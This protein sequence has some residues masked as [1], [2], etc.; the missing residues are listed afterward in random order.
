MLPFLAILGDLLAAEGAAGA[1][2]SAVGPAIAEGAASSAIP[3]VASAA[4][5]AASAA[6]FM[7]G[8]S[9]FMTKAG[10]LGSRMLGDNFVGRTAD[11]AIQSQLQ[12]F[13]GLL[14]KENYQSPEGLMKAFGPFMSPGDRYGAGLMTK[15][16]N[17]KD[18]DSKEKAIKDLLKAQQQ[19]GNL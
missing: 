3:A 10:S 6:S 14:T 4:A 7:P 19:S 11:T 8:V 16:F 15:A 5:P 12:P 17:W 2:G 18:Q 9:G 1:I 13:Q